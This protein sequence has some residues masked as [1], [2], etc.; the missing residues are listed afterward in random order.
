MIENVSDTRNL[1]KECDNDTTEISKQ[2]KDSENLN[3]E[4][5]ECPAFEHHEQSDQKADRSSSFA[6]TSEI[7][8]STGYAHEHD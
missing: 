7:L 1:A 6:A 2:I 5:N 4:A 8:N 3:K